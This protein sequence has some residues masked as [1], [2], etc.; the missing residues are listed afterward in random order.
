VGDVTFVRDGRREYSAFAYGRQWL[1]RAERSEIS[2]DLPLREG[3]VTRRAPSIE[4]SPFPYA[5]ADTEPDAWGK[6]VIQRAHA[7]QRQHD[8]SLKPLTRFDIL[9]AVD[10]FSRIGAL[11]L[12]PRA[13]GSGR[14]RSPGRDSVGAV[15]ATSRNVTGG[16]ESIQLGPAIA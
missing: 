12:R 3:H 10:D 1:A 16:Q 4:D 15:C 6:R 11:R 14:S 7:K 13:G 9:A 5:L 2:P 8:P